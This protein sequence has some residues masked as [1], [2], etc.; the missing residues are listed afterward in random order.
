ML[1]IYLLDIDYPTNIHVYITLYIVLYIYFGNVHSIIYRIAPNFRVF[2]G[3][4]S[5]LENLPRENFVY[6]PI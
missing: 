2:R 1:N 3:S 5:N 4:T 6:A